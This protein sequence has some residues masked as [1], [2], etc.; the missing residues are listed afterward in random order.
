M[1]LSG[2]LANDADVRRFRAEAEAAA[3]LD[4]PGIVP[5]FEVGQ[6]DG[7]QYFSMA[8]VEGQSL[9]RKIVEGL[10][11]PRD[12]ARLVQQIAEAVAYA[13]IEG[14]IHRDL[15]PANILIDTAGQPRLTDFGLAKRV[16]GDRDLTATG[17]ILGTPSYMPPEQ[18]TGQRDVG[19]LA[20]VYSLGAILYCL[21]TGRP[22]FQADNPLDTLMQVVHRDPV[23]PRQ[24]NAAIPKDLETICLKCLEKDPRK[25]YASASDLAADLGRF[26]GGQPIAARP[27][28]SAER[29]WRWCRR[30]PAVAGLAAALLL[31]LVTGSVASTVFAVFAKR[32]AGRATDLADKATREADRATT[33]ERLTRRYLYS[34]HMNL[35]QDAWKAGN[36]PRLLE[37]LDQHRPTDGEDDVRGFDW[38]YLWHQ[39]NGQRQT[40][41]LD[42][43]GFGFAVS[44]DGRW[45]ATGTGYWGGANGV[46]AENAALSAIRLWEVTTGT[47]RRTI[48]GNVEPN[49]T[50]PQ[51]DRMYHQL[52]FSGDGTLFAT[53]TVDYPR[54]E[55]PNEAGLGRREA[56]APRV[57]VWD[58]RTMDV[59]ATIPLPNFTV[60]D[61]IAIAPDNRRIA[62]AF[63][64]IPAKGKP[65][66]TV[67][68]WD[69]PAEAGDPVGAGKVLARREKDSPYDG[70]GRFAFTRDGRFLLWSGTR[71]PQLTVT[72]VSGTGKDS[73]W[74]FGGDH[75]VVSPDGKYLAN[76]WGNRVTLHEA[77]TGKQVHTLDAV[78]DGR[79]GFP[80]PLTLIV[81]HPRVAF[82]PDGRT[83]AVSA[84]AVLDLWD[85]DTK[86]RVG[87]LRGH[88]GTVVA[89][90]FGAAGRTAISV[91]LSRRPPGAEGRV[92][93]VPPAP[94]SVT[95]GPGPRRQTPDEIQALEHHATP[96]LGIAPDG[97]TLAVAGGARPDGSP[98][99]A[100]V[101]Y[102]LSPGSPGRVLG[103]ARADTPKGF[104]PRRASFSP[105]G[106]W[107][108][109][110]GDGDHG[111]PPAPQTHVQL[112]A[113]TRGPTGVR[114]ALRHTFF[115][116]QQFPPAFPLPAFS[117]DGTKLAYPDDHENWHY[118]PRTRVAQGGPHSW[119]FHDL[120][121]G[122]RTQLPADPKSWYPEAERVIGSWQ[123]R[124]RGLGI[125]FSAGG[126]RIFTG[127]HRT[128]IAWDATTG[129]VFCP[130]EVPVLLQ[131][132]GQ[133]LALSPDE[134]T[135]AAVYDDH[136]IT[137][138]D[139]SEPTLQKLHDEQAEWAK[140]FTRTGAP[141]EVKPRVRLRGHADR[142]TAVTFHPDGKV[143]A[144]AGYD[145]TIKLWDVV[146]GEVRLTL[147]GH[148]SP[149]TALAFTP[150]G[151][152]LISADQGGTV[153]FWRAAP[154]DGPAAK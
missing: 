142:V 54:V 48:T 26:L 95:P 22:P 55:P 18:A 101:L 100:V 23:P 122:T 113:L 6:H 79:T 43:D 46:V 139:V 42:G 127:Q 78:P 99:D 108:A 61:R 85:V 89:V 130:W 8:F 39:A 70:V 31:A 143:L 12:A 150:N 41:P 20:D 140:P 51:P 17:Q 1:I 60:E 105:D 83:L 153:R 145:R 117:P 33:S 53:V 77:G 141:A 47:V 71:E 37:L 146:T 25:R 84:G 118:D 75:L 69:L 135:L 50:V 104:R 57:T 103:E 90:G 68:A 82:S 111:D 86:R 36:V 92:W 62:A 151:N 65:T 56:R 9:A 80:L 35:A 21:L 58:L 30:N 120:A 94:D 81:D 66:D 88:D 63:T 109:V 38:R 32:Q 27:V 131:Q 152:T 154:A 16:E 128:L 115:A 29:A 44:P 123:A 7:H 121:T 138:W 91:G 125:V 11:S 102:D 4:H 119:Q 112:W 34:A 59:R 3:R 129:R 45:I 73:A 126:R 132:F 106:R 110:T 76:G 107:L 14:V 74:A 93:D 13:H 67:M 5:V 114:A 136:S 49:Q 19:P 144:S 24:L 52:V 116:P 134:Q 72:D 147:E 148:A 10:P 87:E 124:G 98:S 97:R 64:S 2:Q 15:K 133:A 28:G 96:G 40:I 137:L 149:I